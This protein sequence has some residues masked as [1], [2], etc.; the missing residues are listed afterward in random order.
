MFNHLGSILSLAIG[1]VFLAVLPALAESV[2]TAWVRIYKGPVD[3]VDIPSDIVVDASGNVYVTGASDDGG[4]YGSN[5]DYTTIKY[6]ASGNRLWVKR[7]KGPV[8]GWDWAID[9]ALDASDNV[10]VTGQ[11]LDS[12]GGN[13]YATVQ[14]DSSGNEL[15]ARR[16]DGPA[17][18]TD[19]ASFVVVDSS[20]NIYVTG[21]SE[22]EGTDDDYATIKYGP[23]GSEL[24]VARYNGPDSGRDV[25]SSVA[26][27]RSTNLYV[28]GSSGTIK[29][30]NDGNKLWHRRRGSSDIAI[31]GSGDVYVIGFRAGYVTIKYD[32]LG[33]EL[34]VQRYEEAGKWQ[35]GAFAITLDSSCNVYVTGEGD[36]DYLTVKYDSDG[37]QLWAKKYDGTAKYSED[38]AFDITVDVFGNV[39]VTGVSDGSG[40][41]ED[42]VTIKYD[43]SGNQLWVARY[44]GPE[45][46]FDGA[47]DIVVDASGNVYV[48]GSANGSDAGYDYVTIKYVQTSD[49]PTGSGAR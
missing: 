19:E 38:K 26:L 5:Y 7:Y 14:Y 42:G 47:S 41:R 10:Y 11:S 37:N 2:D 12:N 35:G 46:G 22:G 16:Y 18:G 24:W 13:D 8:D 15:W 25:A 29:Y 33:N 4:E 27:D 1:T 21:T 23:D 40:T 31:D 30:D 34:W 32:S 17:K 43:S 45:N 28:T 9:M 20:G 36:N 6:D 39:Y 48:S 49:S 3:G 44:D